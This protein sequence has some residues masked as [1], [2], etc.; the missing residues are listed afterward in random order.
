MKTLLKLFDATLLGS[1]KCHLH[2]YDF[3]HSLNI[4]SFFWT[5]DKINYPLILAPLKLTIFLPTKQSHW[6]RIRI[7]TPRSL[8]WD[9]CKFCSTYFSHSPSFI[10]HVYIFKFACISKSTMLRIKITNIG[11]QTFNNLVTIIGSAC[12]VDFLN[13]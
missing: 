2:Y 6:L 3:R 5:L 11:N 7:Y 13:E 12:V 1:N 4:V 9:F 10:E 8:K